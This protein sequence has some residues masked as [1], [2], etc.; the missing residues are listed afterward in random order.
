MS[1]CLWFLFFQDNGYGISVPKKDQTANRKVADNFRGLKHLSILH[2][3]GK[4]VFDS[5]NTM[6]EAKRIALEEGHPVIVQ[7]NCVRI[8]S[9]SNSDRHEL[10]RDDFELNYVREYD[11]LAK[12]RRMLLRYKRFT[13]A[14]LD[15]IEKRVKDEVKDAHRKAMAAPDPDPNSIFDFVIAEPYVSNKY[16]EGLHKYQGRIEEANRRN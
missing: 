15:E 3:N 1:N 8:H 11:P 6:L 2:C 9:H 10:Y 5:M 12:F 14:E 4:D 16:P 7:A 13:E